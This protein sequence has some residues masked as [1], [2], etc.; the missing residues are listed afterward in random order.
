MD[1]MRTRL[2]GESSKKQFAIIEAGDLSLSKDVVESIS[3]FLVKISPFSNL[4]QSDN[5][6]WSEIVLNVISSTLDQPTLFN[7]A[8]NPSIPEEAFQILAG[9]Q[10]LALNEFLSTNPSLPQ[11]FLDDFS[12]NE[13]TAIRSA[14]AANPSAPPWLLEKSSRSSIIDVRASVAR[15]PST[16][17]STLLDLA[18]EYDPSAFP[19][20]VNLASNPSGTPEL[21]ERL[22]AKEEAPLTARIASNPFAAG[23]V[24]ERIYQKRA[25]EEN[26][27]LLARNPSLPPKLFDKLHDTQNAKIKMNL[28]RNPRAPGKIIEQIVSENPMDAPYIMG[29]AAN[30]S[31]AE[32]VLSDLEARGE[33]LVRSG[34]PSLLIAILGNPSCPIEL[35]YKHANQY[36]K[37]P[38]SLHAIA[39]N[40]STPGELL[41]EISRVVDLR[42]QHVIAKN[43]ATPTEVLDEYSVAGFTTLCSM[44]AG[45]SSAPSWVLQNLSRS[46]DPRVMRYIASNTRSW[47]HEKPSN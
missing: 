8:Q 1:N 35:L 9:F 39:G 7:F 17:P 29:V 3:S 2:L 27:A 43:R 14:I 34:D 32:H 12:M 6:I 10:N 18:R 20:L 30:P 36:N 5:E 31:T 16:P 21:H 23:R 4:N 47:D 26:W 25:S 24:L 37:V 41:Q 13:S 40:I 22:L 46:N 42:T 11:T 28:A 15:N 44:V 38:S 45:N 19:I 33:S